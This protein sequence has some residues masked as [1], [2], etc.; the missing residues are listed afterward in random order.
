MKYTLLAL[1]IVASASVNAA[2]FDCNKAGTTQEKLICSDVELSELD[3]DLLH[4]YKKVFDIEGMKQNQKNWI[5]LVR[6]KQ[7][8]VDDLISVYSDRI[9]LIELRYSS[10]TN[11]VPV[12]KPET[13]PEEPKEVKVIKPKPEAKKVAKNGKESTYRVEGTPVY[14]YL[15]VSKD[16]SV[17][18]NLIMPIDTTY[19]INGVDRDPNV[20]ITMMNDSDCKG[21]GRGDQYWDQV[22][23]NGFKYKAISQCVQGNKHLTANESWKEITKSM[24]NNQT[25]TVQGVVINTSLMKK[26]VQTLNE[27]NMGDINYAEYMTKME[28]MNK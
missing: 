7:T 5:R 17:G 22:E 25:N 18:F 10:Y 4:S 13:S 14:T 19:A 11:T 9:E 3:S 27:L 2:S 15:T 6:N 28:E 24:I 12:I 20:L 23:V 1:S 26:Y 21:I 8:T 16:D